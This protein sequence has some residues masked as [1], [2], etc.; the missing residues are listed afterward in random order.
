VLIAEWKPIVKYNCAVRDAPRIYTQFPTPGV[1]NSP[2]YSWTAGS[3]LP[4]L[5]ALAMWPNGSTWGDSQL[6]KSERIIKLNHAPARSKEAYRV[7]CVTKLADCIY[8][9]HAFQKK[10]KTGIETPKEENRPYE[11]AI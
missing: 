10:S 6:F 11:D 4:F 7:I 3:R 8:V 1:A 9:L 5:T 2:L